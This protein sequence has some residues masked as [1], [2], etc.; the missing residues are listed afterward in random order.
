MSNHH[1]LFQMERQDAAASREKQG[2]ECGPDTYEWRMIS[3]TISKQ[4]SKTKE[5]KED[6]RTTKSDDCLLKTDNRTEIGTSLDVVAGDNSRTAAICARGV[7]EA[8]RVMHGGTRGTNRRKADT[9]RTTAVTTETTGGS[10][11]CTPLRVSLGEPA[12]P[13]VCTPG[14]TPLP[15]E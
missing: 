1:T 4:D 14:T 3:P 8:S 9:S 12:V 5:K 10:T 7:S 6:M 2:D 11:V 13:N 15:A